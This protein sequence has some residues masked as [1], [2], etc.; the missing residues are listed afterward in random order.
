MLELGGSPGRLEPTLDLLGETVD[1]QPLLSQRVTVAQRDR[2]VLEA[3][4][5]NRK[6]ERCS[7]FVLAAVT[8]ADRAARVVLGV[9]PAPQLRVHLARE[10]GLTVLADERQ[11]RG[12]DGG[13]A[14][15]QPQHDPRLAL[16]RT[17]A[18]DEFLVVGV[19]QEGE[20]GA[21]RARGGLD[22]VRRVALAAGLVEVLELLARELGVLGEIE[23]AA[24]GDP[25]ELRP[26]DRE[27]VFDVA[28][29]RG[30]MRELIGIVRAQAQVIG[31][32]P[33]LRVPALA[34]REPVLEPL[35]GLGGRDEE[36]HLHLLE[37]ARA[38]DEVPGG[39]L[40]A[41][42]LP[43]LRDP[44][45]RFLARE[46]EHVLEVDEDAL[47]GLR[48]Q[49]G[50][51]PGLLHRSDRG[52]EHQVEVARLGQVAL[53][54]FARVLGGFAPA[55]QLGE[56]VGAEALLAGAAVHERVGEA[57]EMARCLP[58]PRVLEDRGVDRDDVVA[59]L[60]HRPPPLALHV[61]LQQH[62]VVAEV[63]GRADPAVDLG[64]G[65]D[66]AAALA[67]GDD[68][69][70]RHRVL[71]RRAP[72]CG[73]R[74]SHQG[75]D[76]SQARRRRG[77]GCLR[78]SPHGRV[79]ERIARRSRCQSDLPKRGVSRR[80]SQATCV[81]DHNR[82]RLQGAQ[83]QAVGE[84]QS[85][86]ETGEVS[87]LIT[88]RELAQDTSLLSVEGDL[89]LASAPSLKWALADVQS[90]ERRHV[91]VDLSR[92]GFIDSTALGVLVGAQRALDP[93]VRLAIACSEENVLRIFELTGLDGMF[94]IVPTLQDALGFVQGSTTAAG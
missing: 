75:E 88:R 83:M 67:E 31:A 91:V 25:L 53:I 40:V 32:D 11:H 42:G 17:L 56:M 27:E 54:G 41:E 51:R 69:L 44:E 82:P 12:L 5:V 15:V 72:T 14:R 24:V 48:A 94:E 61:A 39:D 64:G 58:D 38:E 65:E 18:L 36:L 84:H 7:D 71:R 62:A 37:L 34:L 10:L 89:D 63:V 49:V 85:S 90:A 22:H 16:A 93:G 46:L 70:H 73:A 55:G 60:E 81:T 35:L 6:A 28:R 86:T 3:L 47:R 57:G 23:I 77:E 13:E 78:G 76:A 1:R 43:D 33:E 87:F 74:V 59:L 21:V 4:V 2:A 30:V 52:L 92:V 20:R 68:L 50:G 79:Y 29:A 9:H 66:E 26:A 19:D 45:G 80:R 8:A